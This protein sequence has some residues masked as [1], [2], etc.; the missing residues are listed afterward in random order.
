MTTN[1]CTQRPIDVIENRKQPFSYC[2]TSEV[3]DEATC[4]ALMSYLEDDAPWRLVRQSFYS[5]YEFTLDKDSLS[6]V[7]N[8]LGPVP[9][10]RIRRVIE[11]SFAVQLDD[12]VE[13]VAHKMVKG[14]KIGIHN[15][16]GAP[17]R[18][19]RLVVQ[20]N[21]GLEENHGGQLIFFNS[22]DPGDV[23]RVIQPVHNTAVA[24]ALTSAA[25]H[26]VR[27]ITDGIRYSIVYSFWALPKAAK[28]S[29]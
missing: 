11:D 21:R 29:T 24:F 20:L 10:G 3:Y 22:N 1:I 25:Y 4:E 6:G 5:Q 28:T 27:E 15:D 7:C 8:P 9:L 23:H 16:F 12:R 13:A 17:W 19:H 18:T 14:H 26:A 2:V